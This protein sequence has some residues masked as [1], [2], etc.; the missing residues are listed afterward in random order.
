MTRSVRLH[1]KNRKGSPIKGSPIKGSP[2]KGRFISHTRKK[3]GDKM[4]KATS[5]TVRL[6]RGIAITIISIVSFICAVIG[7]QLYKKKHRS[8]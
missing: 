2:I 1:D 8:V 5:I 4:K 7:F 6:F 3:G